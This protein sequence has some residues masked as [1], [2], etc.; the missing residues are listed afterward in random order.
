[1]HPYEQPY[2]KHQGT[3]RPGHALTA[4]LNGRTLYGANPI[5]QQRQAQ[6]QQGLVALLMARAQQQRR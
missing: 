5:D 2:Q 6:Q 4:M 1:M 3:R